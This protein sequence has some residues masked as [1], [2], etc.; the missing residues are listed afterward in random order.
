LNPIIGKALSEGRSLLL[1]PE[2]KELCSQYGI[3]VPKSKVVASTDE[4]VEA[5]KEIGLPVVVKIV[6]KDIIH[7]VMLAVSS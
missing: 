5:A 2:A 7:R 4:A 1:E 3:P 6:S